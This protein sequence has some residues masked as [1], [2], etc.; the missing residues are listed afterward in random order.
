M[1][2]LVVCGERLG[3]SETSPCGIGSGWVLGGRG[4]GLVMSDSLVSCCMTIGVGGSESWETVVVGVGV[5]AVG[6]TGI[7]AVL[8]WAGTGSLCGWQQWLNL[9]SNW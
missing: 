9:V 6:A 8:R 3:S 1:V 7:S 5:T 4:I 2:V